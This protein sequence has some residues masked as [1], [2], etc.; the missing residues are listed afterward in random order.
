MFDNLTLLAILIIVVWLATLAYFLYSSRQQ[1]DIRRE[2]D[3]LR[4][5]MDR[6]EEEQ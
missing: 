5:L 4:E 6:G 2:L 3:E 1:G